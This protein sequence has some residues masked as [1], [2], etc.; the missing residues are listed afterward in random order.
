MIQNHLIWKRQ[1]D[2]ERDEIERIVVKIMPEKANS[3]YI[4]LMHRPRICP[5]FYIQSLTRYFVIYYLHYLSKSVF[6]W[7][8]PTLTF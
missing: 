2:L 3:F 5:N 6:S 7:E 1:S 8:I 4:F